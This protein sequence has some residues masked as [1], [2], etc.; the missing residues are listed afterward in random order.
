MPGLRLCEVKHAYTHFK[1]T[2][3]AWI[4]RIKTGEPG[5]RP[6]ASKELRW[7]TRSELTEYPFPKANRKVTEAL[8]IWLES[9]RGG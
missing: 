4:C 8:Q 9:R 2:L 5:P 1:I 7:I 6:K 3:N